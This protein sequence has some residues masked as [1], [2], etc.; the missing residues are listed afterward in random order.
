MTRL[1]KLLLIAFVGLLVMALRARAE[2]TPTTLDL[3]GRKITITVPPGWRQNEGTPP[4]FFEEGKKASIQFLL[5]P[6]QM[7]DETFAAMHNAALDGGQAKVKSGD[8]VKAEE[9]AVDGFAGV[10]TVESAKDPTI[11][12]LQWQA[13]GRGGYYNFTMASPGEAFASYLPAFSAMLASIKLP[14]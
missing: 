8:Y 13:Y 6:M 4:T 1:R 12:R 5:S 14:K 9:H 11:R 2:G 7:P 10:L 3:G